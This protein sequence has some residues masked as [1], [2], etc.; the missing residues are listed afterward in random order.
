MEN[1]KKACALWD[2]ME[3]KGETPT[4]EACPSGWNEDHTIHIL[5]APYGI[6]TYEFEV[7]DGD[8]LFEDGDPEED[9]GVP[10]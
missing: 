8:P 5:R 9:D 10:L 1:H 6:G 4:P 2:E 7:E 3:A